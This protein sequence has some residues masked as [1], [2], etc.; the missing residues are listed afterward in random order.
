MILLAAGCLCCTVR[1]DLIA[2]LEDLLRKRDN[3]RIAPFRRVIIETT[4]LADPAPI[5]HAVLYHPYLSMRYALDG[6]ITVVDA[7]N[8][9]GDPRRARGGGEAGRR[10]RP[11][12]RSPRPISCPT[13]HARA[14]AR[15]GCG[16]S[17]P[18]PRSSRRVDGSAAAGGLDR[19]GPVRPRGQDRRRARTGSRPR[20]S[21]RRSGAPRAPARPR[22]HGDDHGHTPS[23]S[24]RQPARRP[25]PRLLPDERRAGPARGA[26]DM[27]LDLLRSSQGAKLLRVKGLVGARGGSGPSGRDPRRRST[28]SMCRRCSRPGRAPTG[29][30]ASSSSSRISTGLRREALGRLPRQPARRRARRGGADDSPL[31]LRG[32]RPRSR[33]QVRVDRIDPGRPSAASAS[34]RRSRRITLPVVVSG[35]FDGTRS[36]A[37][38]RA[39]KAVRARSSGSRARDRRTAQALLEDDERLDDLGAHR[40][41]LADR[42][43]ERHGRVPDQAVLDLARADAI[44]R[45][46]DHVVVAADEV[47]I[48]VAR[49]ARPWSP[50]V[51]QSP[52][53]FASRRV[54]LVP[55]DEEHH[56]VRPRARRS[57]RVRRAR[58]AR[59]PRG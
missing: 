35:R 50:V 24:R 34:S 29:A 39:P 1:G 56:R 49:R 27:F 10:G 37:D 30:A 57:G 21:R 4:G 47:D 48:A 26:L 15:S 8:G 9:A 51:I 17:I 7:V 43:R 41:G 13:R 14:P 58:S 53:N 32:E 2:T 54:G 11:H 16:R 38:I 6:V 12:R 23:R 5:L 59:R 33:S 28:S 22:D 20:P 52:T 46:G 45:R 42:G 3:G 40:I 55:V 44:A 19:R 36:R 31:S 25:H 18:A